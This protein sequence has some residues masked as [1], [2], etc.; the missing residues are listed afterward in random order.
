M[1]MYVSFVYDIIEI[2]F[3]TFGVKVVIKPEEGG[4]GLTSCH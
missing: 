3:K 1:I 2:H 4:G